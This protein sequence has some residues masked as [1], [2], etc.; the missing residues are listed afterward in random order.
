M[1]GRGRRPGE[2]NPAADVVLSDDALIERTLRFSGSYVSDNG[3]VTLRRDPDASYEYTGNAF[4]GFC[5]ACANADLLSPDGEHLPDVR[6]AIAF[7]ATHA[8]DDVD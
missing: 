6:A 8:H 1:T 7:T 2:R 3:C 5:D 4:V